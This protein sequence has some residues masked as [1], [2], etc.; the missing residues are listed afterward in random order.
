M[1][2]RVIRIQDRRPRAKMSEVGS[3]QLPA[4]VQNLNIYS[5]GVGRVSAKPSKCKNEHG[6]V[7]P[8]YSAKPY[9]SSAYS[10]SCQALPSLRV[11]NLLLSR[12]LFRDI[13]FILSRG[14]D[15]QMDEYEAYQMYGGP[16]PESYKQVLRDA[17]N[18]S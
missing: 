7:R 2:M 3:L 13:I 1:R 16:L 12:D 4:P 14:K 17:E 6:Y 18:D 8:L 11:R 9:V 5:R 15:Q 10:E